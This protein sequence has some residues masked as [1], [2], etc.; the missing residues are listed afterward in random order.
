MMAAIVGAGVKK[1]FDYIW[2]KYVSEETK[3]AL[4]S[5]A[6]DAGVSAVVG[7]KSV[8]EW[9]ET[10]ITD[11]D[12]YK[13]RAIKEDNLTY[14]GG[15]LKFSLDDTPDTALEV[16]KVNISFE[17]YFQDRNKQWAKCASSAKFSK[18]YFTSESLAAIEKD[19]VEFKVT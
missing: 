6:I 9:A 4:R 1:G 7:R 18:I 14:V 5:D 17:L 2:N 11:I 19:G 15:K 10:F 16:K 8:E 13:E 3:L 12:E